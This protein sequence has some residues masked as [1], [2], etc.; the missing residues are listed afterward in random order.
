VIS[1]DEH[2]DI[3]VHD[4]EEICLL[5]LDVPASSDDGSTDED[6]LD[7]ETFRDLSTNVIDLVLGQ[8]M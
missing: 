2:A 4:A 5:V 3:R 8:R 1:G 6:D 7:L